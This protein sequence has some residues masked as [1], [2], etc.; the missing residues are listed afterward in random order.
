MTAFTLQA[1]TPAIQL[2]GGMILRLEAISPTTGAAITG[3]T[4]SAWAIYGVDDSDA[5][6]DL[7]SGPFMLVPG[8]VPVG[9]P[10]DGAK[11][12]GGV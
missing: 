3:V 1:G 6:G 2:A 7:T 9:N 5:T 12:T 4:S 10:G 8:P 11:I